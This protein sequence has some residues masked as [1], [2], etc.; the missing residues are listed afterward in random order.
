MLNSNDV[1][2]P[3]IVGLIIPDSDN[4]FYTQLAARIEHEFSKRAISVQVFDSSRSLEKERAHIDEL[5]RMNASGLLLCTAGSDEIEL[6]HNDVFPVTLVDRVVGDFDCVSSDHYRGG[7]ILATYAVDC[8]VRSIA[9]LESDT[10]NN[11]TRSRR[12]GLL[13]SLS[14]DITVDWRKQV[15]PGEMIF[16]AREM[17]KTD[18]IVCTNDRLAIRAMNELSKIGLNVPEDISVVGFDNIPECSLVSPKLTTIK[19][20]VDE[21]AAGAVDT[22]LRR[23]KQPNAVKRSYVYEV[24]IVVRESVKRSVH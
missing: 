22:L 1:I 17:T 11:C 15:A 23:I 3:A 12:E 10:D 18:L 4:G 20:N 13:D 5:K 24:E 9:L 21:I 19:Q 14:D 6:S 8:G 16:A 7:E 2:E